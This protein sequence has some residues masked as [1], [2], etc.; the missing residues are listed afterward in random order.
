MDIS[1]YNE[2]YKSTTLRMF[3]GGKKIELF[4]NGNNV[5]VTAGGRNMGV[6]AGK[7]GPKGDTYIPTQAW[8]SD[9]NG[10][11]WSLTPNDSLKYSAFIP[12]LSTNPTP[13]TSADYAG[14]KWQRVVGDDG[15]V[16]SEQLT[17]IILSAP[18]YT[19][20]NGVQ[21]AEN[22]LYNA[23][24]GEFWVNNTYRSIK[25]P[26]VDGSRVAISSK[27]GAA[28]LFALAVYY[29]VNNVFLGSE[30]T[31]NSGSATIYD[32][33]Y[34]SPPTGTAFIGVTYDN[35]GVNNVY[36]TAY[37]IIFDPVSQTEFEE[38]QA[39]VTS[40]DN[41]VTVL[42]TGG[43]TK[44]ILWLGTSV[45]TGVNTPVTIDGVTTA[46][47]YP[48]MV[49][50]MLKCTVYNEGVGGTR[51]S[52]GDPASYNETTDPLGIGNNVLSSFGFYSALSHTIS[53]KQYIFDNWGTI[54][55][56]FTDAGQ[57]TA[58]CPKTAEELK[59]YSF[60]RKIIAKYLGT[61]PSVSNVDIIVIDH[62]INDMV[63]VIYSGGNVMPAQYSATERMYYWGAINYIM[64]I[65]YASAPQIKICLVSHYRRGEPNL[66]TLY[67]VGKNAANYWQMPFI[68]YA[69]EL[70]TASLMIDVAGYWDVNMI[71]HNTGYT[72]TDNGNNTFTTND[73]GP[74]RYFDYASYMS[75]VQP[76]Q[77]IAGSQLSLSYPVGTWV[78]KE[79]RL[80]ILCPDNLHPHSDASGNA[81]RKIADNI[82]EKL[83]ILL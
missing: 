27:V 30:F 46:N 79:H 22:G 40:I 69:S 5:E 34:I 35:T 57:L 61:N 64:R 1:G 23:N 49:S 82:S 28:A 77:V 59:N 26:Y 17:E 62:S 13:P 3:Q 67:T 25:F 6:L 12:W 39:D 81:N 76:S 8:A 20:I 58:T 21:A 80:N 56:R 10:T 29:D 2:T 50:H 68:D 36:G 52:T 19:S 9:A 53:E 32:K 31:G 54:Y 37:N 60:E 65:I 14:A 47:N 48:A 7:E 42:E 24:N 18:N 16:T 74:Q 78:R 15:E 11:G 55:T 43:T 71:W 33:Q 83:K 51:I 75:I 63:K 41:R 72:F 70:Q 73:Y 4:W 44:K 38:L 66:E 45:P